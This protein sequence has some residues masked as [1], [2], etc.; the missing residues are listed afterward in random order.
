MSITDNIKEFWSHWI[1]I[2]EEE[3]Q[4]NKQDKQNFT[5]IVDQDTNKIIK[6]LKRVIPCNNY[7]INTIQCPKCDEWILK[8]RG[9]QINVQL[10]KPQTN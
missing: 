3:Y 7:S 6:F 10:V 1:E 2:S 5:Y 8:E 4:Q 9:K